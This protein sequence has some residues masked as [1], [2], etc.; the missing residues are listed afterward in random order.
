MNAVEK[1]TK[2]GDMAATLSEALAALERV[3]D[4][5][6]GLEGQIGKE[7]ADAARLR[8]EVEGAIRDLDGLIE[9]RAHG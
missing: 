2:A 9:R 6:A 5:L 7:R 4:R 8:R 1:D 3:A